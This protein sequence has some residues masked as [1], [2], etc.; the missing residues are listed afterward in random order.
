MTFKNCLSKYDTPVLDF[1]HE[2]QRKSVGYDVYLGGGYL[3]DLYY[4]SLNN[5]YKE[6]KDIDLFFI[7]KNNNKSVIRETPVI[8]K[9]M[10]T[11][12]VSSD[13]IKDMRENVERVI[14]L[15][16][17][18][19]TPQEVQLIFYKQHMTHQEL[20]KDMDC[21]IC[22][23]MYHIES[24]KMVH[25]YDFFLGHKE[26]VIKMLHTFEQNRMYSRLKRMM[27]KFP[28]YSLV[29]N[30]DPTKWEELESKHKTSSTSFKVPRGGSFIAD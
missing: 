30:I 5:T 14:G 1:L 16:N 28:N 22:Q 2:V 27:E 15:K 29:H 24:D 21:N 18:N 8:P 23:I 19:T 6:P 17:Y 20:V 13:E 9:T 3:R 26:K 7:P 10:V 11:Y 25:S 12:D 4:S